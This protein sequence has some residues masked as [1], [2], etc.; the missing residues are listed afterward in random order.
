M[1]GS[2]L[3]DTLSGDGD[4]NVLSGNGGPDLLNGRGG[5]DQIDGGDGDDTIAISGNEA[6]TDQLQGGLGNDQIINVGTG[7]A[8]LSG[9]NSSFTAFENSIEKYDGGGKALL[10]ND[11]TNQLHFSFTLFTN[12]PGVQG[13]L[14]DDDITTSLNNNSGGA[15][16]AYDG[17]DGLLDHVTLLFTPSQ[18]AA[19]TATDFPVLQSYVVNPTGQ[20]LT[21][22]GTAAKGNLL[23]TN[24]EK[25]DIAVA[26]DGQLIRVTS[27]FTSLSSRSQLIVGDDAAADSLTGTPLADLIFGQGGNDWI[28]G[29]A[30][31]DC[32]FGGAGGDSLWGDVGIDQIYGGSGDDVVSGGLD[33][34]QIDGGA[35]NDQLAGDAG[36]DVVRGG[37]G[38]D[39][40]SGGG[41]PDTLN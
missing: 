15:P 20:T 33:A 19:L 40:L 5:V 3:G 14:G 11:A 13:G 6:E 37:V 8:K 21:L 22:T 35:G 41:E 30:G 36:S 7:P 17:G 31:N 2:A 4:A 12:T 1:L 38:N 28:N 34:D 16:V 9:F 29:A 24:F 23:A 26:D 25:A 18:L 10:G 32:I 39:T 27:C